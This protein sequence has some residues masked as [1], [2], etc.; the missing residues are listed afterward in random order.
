MEEEFRDVVLNAIDIE[1]LTKTL[2]NS[3]EMSTQNYEDYFYLECIIR[4]IM[5]KTLSLR[6]QVVYLQNEIK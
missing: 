1:H 4:I 6:K 5:E 3:F 2:Q